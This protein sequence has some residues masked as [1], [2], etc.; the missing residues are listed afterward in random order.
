MAVEIG[1]NKEGKLLD[2]N[3][4]PVPPSVAIDLSACQVRYLTFLLSSSLG[5][6]SVPDY[7]CHAVSSCFLQAV[8]S[9][10][11]TPEYVRGVER[12]EGG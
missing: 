6:A 4:L 11:K 9:P 7:W 2:A 12:G 5:C 8:I 10:G 1:K 3:G